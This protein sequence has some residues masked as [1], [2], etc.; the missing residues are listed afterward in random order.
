[1]GEGL[2]QWLHTELTS[3]ILVS[4]RRFKVTQV[5][6]AF[7]NFNHSCSHQFLYIKNVRK[8]DIQK[9]S[10]KMI[11]KRTPNKLSIHFFDQTK[12]WLDILEKGWQ[13]SK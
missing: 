13:Q 9:F 7:Q 8:T 2:K 11:D 12:S 4:S 1:M 10:I 5:T 6:Q 3:D